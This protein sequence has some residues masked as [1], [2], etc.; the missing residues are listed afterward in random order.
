MMS[1]SSA[2]PL[3]QCLS[4]LV[5]VFAVAGETKITMHH[6]CKVVLLK[7]VAWMVWG[8]NMKWTMETAKILV[9]SK[10]VLPTW[11]KRRSHIF[12]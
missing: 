7:V 1:V 6:Y 12:L 4:R 3:S 9:K 10:C 11:L 2:V 5:D 8:A